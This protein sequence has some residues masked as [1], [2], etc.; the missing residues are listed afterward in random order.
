MYIDI[1]DVT[2]LIS[3]L[4]LAVSIV[5]LTYP[6]SD[7]KFLNKLQNHTERRLVAWMNIRRSVMY[8]IVFILVLISRMEVEIIG[9]YDTQKYT[10]LAMVTATFIC[11]AMAVIDRWRLSHHGY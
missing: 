5:N 8:I 3:V 1:W 7:L 11:A 10:I 4:G 6:I 2:L 9:T